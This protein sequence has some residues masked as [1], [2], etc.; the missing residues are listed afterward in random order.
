MP[1][2]QIVEATAGNTFEASLAA[3]DDLIGRLAREG[4]GAPRW[5]APR[6]PFVWRRRARLRRRR[7]AW[8]GPDGARPGPRSARPSW[9][10]P[11][12][13]GM[14]GFGA[15]SRWLEETFAE[16]M[17][18]AAS[19]QLEAGGMGPFCPWLSNT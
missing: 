15:R 19:A 9:R 17:A 1:S 7:V 16:Q 11:A 3:I 8:G 14:P 6:A 5:R 12:S 4:L 18:A 13:G 10:L 2:L